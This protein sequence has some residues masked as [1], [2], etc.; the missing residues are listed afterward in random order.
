MVEVE[1]I[2]AVEILAAARLSGLSPHMVTYLERSGVS[3]PGARVAHRGRARMYSP[4]DVIYLKLLRVMLDHGIEV[5]RVAPALQLA[6]AQTLAAM[7]QG[8]PEGIFL[9]TDGVRVTLGHKTKDGAKSVGA[10]FGFA[11]VFD[12]DAAFADIMADWPKKSGSAA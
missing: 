5:K 2:L 1:T 4:V 6:K 11:F 3:A 7:D 12:L 10:E 9:M 8:G